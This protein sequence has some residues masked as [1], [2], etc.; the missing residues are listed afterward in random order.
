MGTRQG[1]PISS[2]IQGYR[3]TDT[4]SLGAYINNLKFAD[5]I[6]MIK[7]DRNKLQENMNELRKAGEAAGL[8]IDIGKQKQ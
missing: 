3:S 6:D 4:K 1:D 7:E 2:E 5:D 8:K